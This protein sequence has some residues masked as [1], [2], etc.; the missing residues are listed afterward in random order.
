MRKV[1]WGIFAGI[2]AMVVFF[3]TVGVIAAFII[4]NSIAG[5]THTVATMFDEWWQTA[6]FVVDIIFAIG[7]VVSLVMYI[8]NAIAGRREET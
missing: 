1:P 7:F 2:C 8:R 3:S 6:L 4:L 5:Q